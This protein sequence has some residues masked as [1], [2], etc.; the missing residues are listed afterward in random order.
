M[1]TTGVWVVRDVKH[2]CGTRVRCV[3]T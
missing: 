1:L 3:Y 2:G